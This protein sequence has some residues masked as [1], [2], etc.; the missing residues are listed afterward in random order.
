MTT[1]YKV[2]TRDTDGSTKRTYKTIGGALKRFEEMAGF[3]VKVAFEEMT[4]GKA[5]LD[6]R[7]IRY[8]RGVS[9]YGTVVMFE[10]IGDAEPVPAPA[11]A[12]VVDVAKRLAEVREALEGARE[13]HGDT[14]AQHRSETAAF[15]DSWPGAQSQI[16]G[17]AKAIDALECELENL[18]ATPEGQAIERAEVEAARATLAECVEDGRDPFDGCP[19]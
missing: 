12:P 17:Q 14:V 8:A 5:A 19:F 4:E 6:E 11:P 18:L 7:E 16:A 2:T 10:R 3:G 15:G 9:M 13:C 1:T